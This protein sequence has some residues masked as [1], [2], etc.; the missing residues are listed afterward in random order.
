MRVLTLSLANSNHDTNEFKIR[1]P[2]FKK[3]S[4]SAQLTFSASNQAKPDMNYLIQMHQIFMF[5]VSVNLGLRLVR[6]DLTS[7][8]ILFQKQ[9]HN[10]IKYYHTGNKFCTAPL[11]ETKKTNTQN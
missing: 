9:P 11:L 10:K 1:L 4:E 8:Q 2:Y 7:I 6:H 5:I 3:A